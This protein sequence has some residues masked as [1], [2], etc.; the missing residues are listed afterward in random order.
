MYEIL[1]Y[2]VMELIK[3][4]FSEPL[5]TKEKFWNHDGSILFK[6]GRENTLENCSEK[7]ACEI[8]NLIDLPTVH[9]DLAVYKN[10]DEKLGVVSKNFLKDGEELILA[11]TLLADN[12]SKYDKEKIYKLKEYTLNDFVSIIIKQNKNGDDVHNFTGYLIFGQSR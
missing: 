10:G 8:A 5:G 2:E 4:H 7:I 9:Y 6:V 11:N 12:L 1:E 3:L